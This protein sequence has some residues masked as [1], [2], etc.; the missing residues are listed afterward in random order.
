MAV[1]NTVNRWCVLT[2]AFFLLLVNVTSCSAKPAAEVPD[3]AL[4]VWNELRIAIL[5][6]NPDG[7]S[8][9]SHFPLR[10]LDARF[11]LLKDATALKENYGKIFDEQL[12]DLVLSNQVTLGP[13]DPGFE[14]M[15]GEGYM[16]FGFEPF[17][18]DYKLTYLGSINE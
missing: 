9:L 6:D 10:F 5:E 7:V 18:G 1:Y 4:Q 2:A 17:E 16:I 14:V 8:A 11:D 13:G 12:V 3:N 15:C